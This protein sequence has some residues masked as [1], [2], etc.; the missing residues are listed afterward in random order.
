[1]SRIVS[2]EEFERVL[3]QKLNSL[4]HSVKCVTG[5]G[6]SGAIAAVYTSYILGVPFIPYG[7]NIPDKLTPI[8][9]VDTA[10]KS[11]KTLRK[12][13]VKYEDYKPV[14]L[15]CYDEPPRVHFWYEMI[16]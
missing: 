11:G 2:C 13:E 5:P 1:M 9:I 3:T 14:T 12:A 4:K 10:R 6:R 8:L 16:S 7:T 15:W